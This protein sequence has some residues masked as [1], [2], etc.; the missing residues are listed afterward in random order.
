MDWSKAKT[1]LITVFLAINIF[2]AY[3][4][5]G[6]NTGSIGYVD[7]ESVKQI[8][9]YLAE[10]DIKV[11]GQVP[12]KKLEMPSITVKYQLFNKED[13]AKRIFLPEIKVKESID[14][15]TVKLSGD[16]LE[17]SIKDSRELVFID[18]SIKPSAAI[19]QKTCS[20]HIKEFLDRLGL[21]DN[22]DIRQVEDLEGYKR[23]VYGQSFKGA[24]IYNSVMEFYVND[25]GVQ[26]ARITWF[27]TVKQASR[28]ANVISPEIALLSLTKYKADIAAQSIEVWEV[29]QGYYFGTGASGQVDTSKVVEGTAFP[30]WKITTD[31]DMIY[32][33]AY[34]E[35][36]ESVEKA[37]K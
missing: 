30:V 33:N 18:S 25:A 8:T 12:L 3:M 27:D 10:R 29:Q 19:D 11:K 36:V 22:A 9:N 24:V 34:N 35:K 32:I 20:N 23:F 2:L 31:K 1:I 21:K 7:D 4:I 26:R 14:G 6:A 37:R 17:I 15:S 28:K 5:I 16:S 13:I